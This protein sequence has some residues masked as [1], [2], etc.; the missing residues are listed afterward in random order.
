MAQKIRLRH[1]CCVAEA[2][3]ERGIFELLCEEVGA[4]QL[5]GD[6]CDEHLLVG[7]RFT[8]LIFSEI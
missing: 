7:L 1:H 4:V 6:V 5:A 2:A 8:D 3:I